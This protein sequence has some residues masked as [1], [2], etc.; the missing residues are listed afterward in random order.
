[1]RARATRGV[2]GVGSDGDCG[3]SHDEPIASKNIIKSGHTIDLVG[4][5]PL[6]VGLPHPLTRM[7]GAG[8]SSSR[9]RLR[10]R[11]NKTALHLELESAGVAKD[12]RQ[13]QTEK[14][15]DVR[16]SPRRYFR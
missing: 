11:E 6:P 5:S 2:A 8:R 13:L 15:L 12:A 7:R 1:M 4:Q 10:E 9:R 16:P 3:L 14:T